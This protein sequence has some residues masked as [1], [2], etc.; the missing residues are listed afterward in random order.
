MLHPLGLESFQKAQGGRKIG[1]GSGQSRCRASDEDLAEVL[2]RS[3][4][5][6]QGA[7]ASEGNPSRQQGWRDVLLWVV[8]AVLLRWFVLE[9]RWI[10]SGSMLPTLE[11]KDR[12]LVEKIRPKLADQR[13]RALGIGDVVVFSVPEALIDA[14]YDPNTALIKRVVAGP[15]DT[16][17]VRDGELRRNGQTVNEPWRDD[18]MDY[19]MSERTV[20][21]GALWVLGDNRNASLDSHLWGPLPQ[22]QVIG[23]AVWRYWPLNRFGPI[24]FPR[25]ARSDDTQAVGLGSES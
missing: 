7:M 14:G 5:Y 20:P 6:M 2:M 17:E 10:P 1:N 24:R 12:I 21:A 3:S 15:G 22:E 9:P 13:H 25:Q 16:V 23:T 11:L 4:L 19:V 18:A 8:L